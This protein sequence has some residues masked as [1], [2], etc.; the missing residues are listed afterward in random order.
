M[1]L[2]RVLVGTLVICTL[3]ITGCQKQ[4]MYES[5]VSKVQEYN[6]GVANVKKL[7]NDNEAKA[8]SNETLVAHMI[9]CNEITKEGYQLFNLPDAPEK[10]DGETDEHYMYRCM[11]TLFD[12][13]IIKPYEEYN[14]FQNELTSFSDSLGNFVYKYEDDYIINSGYFSSVDSNFLCQFLVIDNLYS[15]ILKARIYWAD[16]KIQGVVIQ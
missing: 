16:G 15:N 9:S 4:S 2:K 13:S 3:C 8:R 6:N 11:N 10:E 1:F 14:N 7:F 5:Q 12:K